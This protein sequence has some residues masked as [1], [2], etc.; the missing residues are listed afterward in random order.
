MNFM[1]LQPPSPSLQENEPM[2]TASEEEEREENEEEEEEEEEED[3]D[4]RSSDEEGG[5][6]LVAMTTEPELIK[7]T[8]EEDAEIQT[9][10]EQESHG[11]KGVCAYEAHACVYV[12]DPPSNQSF[13]SVTATA[14]TASPVGGPT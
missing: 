4:P 9:A 2:Q 5:L 7:K 8:T 10:S 11:G 1:S 3:K 14:A 13:Q 12:P 6:S